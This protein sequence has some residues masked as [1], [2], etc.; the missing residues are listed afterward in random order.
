[1]RREVITG[2]YANPVD[3]PELKE[4]CGCHVR[5]FLCKPNEDSAFILTI[6]DK[7]YTPD[8]FM[9][10]A[11]RLGVS[12]R[13]PFIPKDLVLGQ[14]VA[15][16]AHNRACQINTNEPLP[17]SNESDVMETTRIEYKYGIFT[18]FIPQRVEKLIWRHDATEDELK[19]LEKS[20]ITPVITEDG[21]MD[22]VA[23]PPAWINK[24][25]KLMRESE[26][27]A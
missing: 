5:C 21:D 6:G 3:F 26:A 18:A 1:M 10:E 12:K 24:A 8:S 27:L 23:P 14:T 22:H 2:S 11:R 15:Y 13:I 25:R 17:L 20:G 7:F 16:L 4:P 9:D 19:R